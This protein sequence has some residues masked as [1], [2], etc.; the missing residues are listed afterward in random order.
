MSFE[1]V[2]VLAIAW[3]P[4]AWAALEWNCAGRRAA[5]V[6]KTASIA[7]ILI[8]LSAPRMAITSSR[9]AVALL[10]DTSASVSKTDLEKASRFAAAMN[11]ER[12]SHWTRVIPFAGATRDPAPAESGTSWRF[13]TASGESARS[14]DLEAAIREAIST[15]PSDQV[16]RI[17]ILSDG[18]ETKGSVARAAWQARGLGIPIDTV[19][20]GGRTKAS[21]QL[22]SVRM[23]TEAFTGEP[24][25]I[26]LEVSAAVSGPAEVELDAE[27][28]QI[29]RA[30]AALTAGSNRVLLHTSLNTPGALEISIV[31]RAGSATI[32]QKPDAGE[33]RFDQSI[34]M[35]RPRALYLTGDQPALDT[36]FLQALAAA[37]FEA[38]RAAAVT[39]ATK[40]SGYELVILNNWALDKIARQTQ[41]NLETYVK[42]GGG[43][44]VISGDHNLYA[45]GSHIGETLD[46]VLPA[47]LAP[48]APDGRAVVLVLDRS[49]SM[50]GPKIDFAR[51][52]AAG[53]VEHL[54]PIDQV[55][56]LVFDTSF[57]WQIPIRFADNR[58]SIN[59]LISRITANG[60]TRIAPALNEGYRE[61]LGTTAFYKHII[62]LTDGLS[63]E[64]NSYN[65]AR[66]AGE[67]AITIST[68]GL[69]RDVNRNYLRRIANLAGGKSYLV[70]DPTG[71]EQI[72]ISD[73][74]EH[75]GMSAIEAP[76]VPEILRPAE[77]LD[78]VDIRHA[79]ALQ[80]Y[81]RFEPKPASETIL[82]VDQKNPLLTRWQ[83]GLGR[84]AIFTSD[85]KAQWAASW[86]TWKGYDKFWS[87]VCRDLL[88]HAHSAEAD[89]SYDSASG[90]LIATYR[91]NAATGGDAPIRPPAIFV[92]G[93]SGFQSA[94]PVKKIAE[95]A[96]RGSVHVGARQGLFRVRPLV[97]SDT[98]PEAGL[99][100]PEAELSVYG[101]N[102][103]LLHQ[104]AAFTGGKFQPS[105]RD[106]FA[107]D[108]R[109]VRVVWQLW[110]WLLALA[111]GLSL[112]ELVLRKRWRS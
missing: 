68:V 88:P 9:V 26:E 112:A 17:A 19:A 69:G 91:M 96:Y 107:P 8:A 20:L 30:R 99:Y 95:G 50:L 89:L 73:V 27:G 101:S 98:F 55:G 97:D 86:V 28:R 25:P 23:P 32:A 67:N 100:R 62:L 78:G 66:E 81:I 83:Y 6:L 11:G 80:G 77:I 46:R 76:I 63:D 22:E 5:L 108:G 84:A 10:V 56:V 110:P 58:E 90:E 92:I 53:V 70:D 60:G 71:L 93:P 4:L 82:R 49:T 54:T 102:E 2:W 94:L 48:R 39:P 18:R 61:I 111:L 40:F 109:S 16:P 37:Q 104:M 52:A 105:P 35:R 75:T 42:R 64:G 13:R 41:A 38:V 7:A 74:K 36:H 14:T 44:L 15:L 103:A 12:G 72:V 47:K 33:L 1:H 106:V 24:F 3:I 43:L 51:R 57:L 85:A 87:N 45:E 59:W 21:V 34:T 31:I 65:L 29:A 79:P